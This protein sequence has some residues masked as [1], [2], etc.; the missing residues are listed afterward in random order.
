MSRF[1]VVELDDLEELYEIC[2]TFISKHNISCPDAICQVDSILLDAD[3]L[4]EK[5]CEVVGYVND[6]EED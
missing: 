6:G 4:I 1:S 2:K 5:I 3:N